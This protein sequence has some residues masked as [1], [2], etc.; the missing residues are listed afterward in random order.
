MPEPQQALVHMFL[1]GAILAV[2]AGLPA[3][4]LF[5]RQR[6][7][8]LLPP[9]EPWSI[10][11]NGLAVLLAFI[12]SV[13]VAA[14]AQTLLS[15]SGFFN[16]L[17]GADFPT[18]LSAD[19]L[20]D[21]VRKH[22]AHLMTL[23]SQAIAMP[24][25]LVLVI[26][27]ITLG[28]R[29]SFSQI[30]LARASAGPNLIVGYL[31]WLTL[32]PLVFGI[33]V[34]ALAWLAPNP[35]PHPL[36]D[37]GERAGKREWLVFAIQ[38]AILAPLSEELLFRGLLLPWLAQLPQA[39][40]IDPALLVQPG[41]RSHVVYAAAL[42]LTSGKTIEAVMDGHW[43]QIVPLP[44]TLLFIAAL[45]PFYLLLPRSGRLQRWTGLHTQSVRA[46]L[47]S[48]A[49]FAAVHAA[50]PSPIPLFFLGLGLGWL[51][52]RTRS[53]VPGVVVHGM[54]NSLAVVYTFL[55]GMP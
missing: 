51:A 33:F 31:G 43:D 28:T 25:S 48:A 4:V 9:A 40:R 16:A 29:A 47:A 1:A 50:W 52:L 19:D 46:V 24:F 39:D 2:A 55:S 37:L 32:T 21:P 10:T 53:I 34:L 12:L 41:H 54:F 36:M 26:A 7:T 42:L 27:G 6:P 35:E 15:K 18:S 3:L 23:W 17:Y 13:L 14:I 30:G 44:P 20:H 5:L 8:P 22:A 49:L 45:L 11:W 38:V